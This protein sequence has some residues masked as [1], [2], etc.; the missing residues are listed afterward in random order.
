[1]SPDV[2]VAQGKYQ[3]KLLVPTAEGMT[4]LVLKCDTVREDTVVTVGEGLR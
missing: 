3:I 1:M 2:S 4:D